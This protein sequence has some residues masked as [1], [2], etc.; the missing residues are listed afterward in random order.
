LLVLSWLLTF[1]D[2]LLAGESVALRDIETGTALR[3]IRPLPDHAHA[4][5]AI[6]QNGE[7]F[8]FHPVAQ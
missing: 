4:D 3:V 8:D 6:R 5:A 7:I 1:D 2:E